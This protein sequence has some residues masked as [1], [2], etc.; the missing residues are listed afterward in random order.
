MR[1]H[2]SKDNLEFK[3][4]FVFIVAIETVTQ[5]SHVMSIMFMTSVSKKSDNSE[6]HIQN[7]V[8]YDSVHKLGRSITI[9]SLLVILSIYLFLVKTNLAMVICMLHVHN[10]KVKCDVLLQKHK[11]DLSRFILFLSLTLVIVCYKR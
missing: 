11:H 3:Y 1:A 6:G 5:C 2:F 7:T 4:F 10:M 9:L 8:N